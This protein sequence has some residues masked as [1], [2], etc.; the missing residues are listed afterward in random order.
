MVTD[1]S[2]RLLA[3][4]ERRED[5]ARYQ[6]QPPK[7]WVVRDMAYL[8][9]LR[10]IVELHQVFPYLMPPAPGVLLCKTCGMA[11]GPWPCETI[12]AVAEAL[13]VSP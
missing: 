12:A 5:Y 13:D 6:N 9:A 10:K 4:L 2:A 1:L 8:E 7:P 3:E 11:G